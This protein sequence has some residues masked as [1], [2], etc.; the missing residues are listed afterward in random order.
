LVEVTGAV[1]TLQFAKHVCRIDMQ[2]AAY[3]AGYGE[4]SGEQYGKRNR[5]KYEWVLC[6][7]LEHDDRKD[8]ARGDTQQQ[9]YD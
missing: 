9:P 4:Q 5:R 1:I 2:G 3:R 8:S 7:R 6:R